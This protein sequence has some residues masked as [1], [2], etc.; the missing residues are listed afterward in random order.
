MNGEDLGGQVAMGTDGVSPLV[1]LDI[2][3]GPPLLPNGA[4]N[5]AAQAVSPEHSTVKHPNLAPLKGYLQTSE[6]CGSCHELTIPVLN[7]GMPEQRTY[8]EWKYSA[9]GDPNGP[10]FRTCQDCH[11]PRLSHEYTDDIVGSF[12]ADPFGEPGGWPYSKPRT[13]TA[14]HELAGA[15]RDLP[16]MMKLLYREVDF[17]VI[18]GAGV[19]GGTNFGVGTGNDPRIFPGMLSTRDSMWDRNR[20]NTEV[21]LMDAADVSIV[22]GPRLIDDQAGVWELE[23]KVTN[24]TGHRL[25][26]GYP[27][28]RRMWLGIQVMDATGASQV[29]FYESGWYDDATATLFTDGTPTPFRRALTSTIDATIPGGNAVMS[30]ERVTGTCEFDPVTGERVGCTPSL[31]LLNDH[32]LFDNRIPPDG[33]SYGAYRLSGVKFWS[34]VPG[35]APDTIVPFEDAGRYPDGQGFDVVTYRFLADPGAQLVA[36]AELFYQSHTRELMEHLRERDTSFVRPQGPPRPWVANYPLMPNYLSEELP[37]DEAAFQAREAGFLDADEALNDNW[38][39]IAYA[40]WF[41]TGRGAPFS[42]GAAEVRGSAESPAAR[43]SPPDA[44]TGLHVYPEWNDDPEG[45]PVPTGGMPMQ[46]PEAG[47]FI[48]PFTQVIAWDRV[49]GADGYLVRI[50][51]GKPGTTTAS[52]DKLAIVPERPDP[53]PDCAPNQPF[54]CLVNT[55]INVNKTYTYTVQAFN[56]GGFGD[57]SAPKAGR[58][59]WD[60][61]F[62]PLNLTCSQI[63]AR[64]VTLTW[65]DQADNESGFRIENYLVPLGNP[66]EPAAWSF[67]ADVASP[68][69]PT[70]GGFSQQVTGLLPGRTYNWQVGAYNDSGILYSLPATC[71][72][73]SAPIAA[74]GLTATSV[75]AFQVDLQWSDP[76]GGETGFRIERALDLGFTSGLA[77]FT[78]AANTT[79]YADGTVEPGTAYFYRVFAFNAD[80]D[81][82]PSNVVEVTTPEVPP[83]APTGL[84][85]TPSGPGVRPVTVSLTWVDASSNETGFE[86]QRS[87]DPTF[88]AGTATWNL[89]ADARAFV[90]DTAEP[91]KTYHYRIRAFNG[92]G[93]SAWSETTVVTPGEPPE[94][95]SS[96]SVLGVTSRSVYLAWLDRSNNELGFH[97]ERSGPAG[98][99]VLTLPR[100]TMSH[101][102]SGLARGTRYT[103]RL[104]AFNADGVSAWTAPLLVRTR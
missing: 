34:H 84:A 91:V 86:L 102:D 54:P 18:G 80:G 10:E 33:F 44:I 61:P 60:I 51:Y 15:N 70:Y 104:R 66:T 93:A 55:S 37:L 16:E 49:S 41:L 64:S 90:D 96:L 92:V 20:R 74:A 12:N 76:S 7:H 75:G 40:A 47:P 69:L 62:E 57:E 22:G 32:V 83:Q 78:V 72:T 77:S 42:M 67:V 9:Y 26:S 36:R 48:E 97:L 94:A 24:L 88:A 99:V 21:N 30:Y 17:E 81:S 31:S 11:M 39:G 4:P 98:T 14:V 52:W 82:D 65:F 29:P 89:P 5:Y 13:N 1:Q 63:G 58:T 23:V 79:A 85:G 8:S 46:I 3:I 87:L 35:A 43:I 2:P 19:E 68:G 71:T 100:N 27:D 53:Q 50:K 73:R 38:G 101:L 56:G 103:Y 59:P 28:G 95:P 45:R 25:P 6:F